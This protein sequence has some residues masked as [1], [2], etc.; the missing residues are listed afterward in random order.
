MKILGALMPPKPNDDI[1]VQV[2]LHNAPR[3]KRLYARHGWLFISLLFG[4]PLLFWAISGY[5]EQLWFVKRA[6]ALFSFHTD[7][8]VLG[9]ATGMLLSMAFTAPIANWLIEGLVGKDFMAIYKV[10]YDQHPNHKINSAAFSHLLQWIFV[11]LTILTVWYIRYDYTIVTQDKLI[12]GQWLKFSERVA[13][14]NTITSIER[15]IGEIAP[16]GNYKTGFRY[17]LV[18]QQDKPWESRF[19]SGSLDPEHLQCQPMMEY[20]LAKTK[21]EM[22]EWETP[23]N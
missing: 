1:P 7:H 17:R 23:V 22:V 18:F 20:L 8:G 21:L 15:Q 5:L 9:F 11:P 2:I 4:I 14:L 10:W 19:F 16:N 3:C 13:P 12:E 6:D